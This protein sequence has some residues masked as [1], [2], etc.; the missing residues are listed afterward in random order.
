MSPLTFLKG[1]AT[2][3]GLSMTLPGL[4]DFYMV[5]QWAGSP[6]LTMVT[7][8]GRKVVKSI[9]DEDGKTFF[10]GPAS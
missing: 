4:K 10:P 2:G 6:G 8:M 7:A 3:K 5:G 9:C 1:A